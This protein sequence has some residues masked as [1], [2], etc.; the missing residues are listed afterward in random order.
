MPDYSKVISPAQRKCI[1]DVDQFCYICGSYTLER[2]RQKVIDF[3][4]NLYLDNFRMELGDQEKSSAPHIVCKHVL[5]I[6]GARQFAFGM[7]MI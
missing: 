7:H 1:N 4:K 5:Q 3:V 6:L 2:Q